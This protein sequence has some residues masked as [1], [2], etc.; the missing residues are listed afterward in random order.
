M[1][2]EGARSVLPSK[3]LLD[4]EHEIVI[5]LLGGGEGLLEEV[6]AA[7]PVEFSD[8]EGGAGAFAGSTDDGEVVALLGGE[9]LDG[10]PD[11]LALVVH[12]RLTRARRRAEPAAQTGL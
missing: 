1:I 7:G 4:A 12:G 11:E 9:A 8:V 5:V 3:P 10:G 2:R 6:L